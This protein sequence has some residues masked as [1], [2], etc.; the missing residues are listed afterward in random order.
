MQICN[1]KAFKGRNI[2]SHNEVIKLVVDLE[3][4]TD[5]PTNEIDGFNENLLKYLPG[6]KKHACSLGYEGG[7][8]KRLTDGTYLAHVIEHSAIEML[9]MLGYNIGF[10]KARQV[11]NTSKHIIVYSYINEV[12]GIEIGKLAFKLIKNLCHGQKIDL[13]TKLKIIKEK[14]DKYEFGPSTR[15]IIDAAKAEGIPLT[16]IGNRSLFQLG[17]GKYQKRIEA[18]IPESTSCIAV[19]IACDKSTTKQILHEMD[20][21]IPIGEVC[22]T[23]NDAVLIAEEI[24][25][26][27]VV[28]PENGNQGKGVS[29]G[30][31]NENE[32]AFA[33]NIAKK[34]SDYVM[35]EKYIPGNDY[36]VLVVGDKVA[37]VAQR[38]PAYVIGDGKHPISYLINLKNMDPLRGE[39]H[40]KPLTKI[41][42]DEVTIAV[43][44]KQNYTLDSI[45]G[46]DKKIYL[47]NNANLSTGGEAIDCT[48]KIHPVNCQLAIQASKIIGLDI[49]GVDITCKDISIPITQSGGA[50]IEV[51]ASPGLRM[52]LHPSKG[53]PREVGKTIIDFLYPPN[54]KNSIPIVSI[55]GTNGKTTTV[56]MIG[57]IL[58]VNGLNVGMTTTGGVYIND[59]CVIEGDTTGPASAQSIFRDKSIDIAILE[60]A[61][62]GIIRSG[63]GYDLS[64]IGVLTNISEDHL[65]IDGIYT[66]D[67][68][69][70]VKSLV[71]EAIKEDGY[72]VLNADDPM[73]VKAAK[74]V[75]CKIIYFSKMENN[76]IV[77]KHLQSNG[78]GVFLRDGYITIGTGNSFV[79]S[80]HISK[81]PATYNG[82]LVHNVENSLA[83]VSIAYALNVP[84][85][86]IEKGLCSFYSDE[87]QNPGR[88]N[89]FNVKDFR[90]IVDYGH[91]IAGYKAVAEAVKDMGANRL[92]GIIGVPGDRDDES[93]K[94][95]GR[96]AAQ[97]FDDIIIKEDLDLRGRTRGEVASILQEGALS[98]GINKD[99]IKIIYKET[100]ALKWAMLQAK[101]GDLIV[102][103]FEHFKPIVDIIKNASLNSN[104]F[105][106]SKMSMQL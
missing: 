102:I 44:K 16:H 57:H 86:I 37:A 88:F 82:K 31:N 87:L 60:T 100:E 95:V 69:L 41:K 22:T 68:L 35:V 106:A 79:Q 24:G 61:R 58:K 85:S 80:I 38:V 40:E 92:I 55:T 42:I 25:Y 2:Y 3:E 104:A 47:K 20:I 7:F 99:H 10:G 26:P 32:V 34:I 105:K 6:L 66:T 89:I 91:N 29:I 48:D 54:S 23:C 49:A 14:A 21:P 9:N 81:I 4:W 43:L 5:I 56:R 12:A 15:A 8:V 74:N 96:F 18:T 30:L 67:D 28:K 1:I 59:K 50:I 33:F 70:F 51:N 72:A 94:E 73:V 65:G 39:G 90:V 36:R 45:P 52:H 17:Y 53:K 13:D 93:I 11:D 46:S 19:D 101:P 62:G 64:D 63:L 83:A 78:I 75:R 71:L 97:M 84:L 76:I 98:A 103:F 77:H 27:V